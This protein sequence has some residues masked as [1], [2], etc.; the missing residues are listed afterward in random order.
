MTG[1]NIGPFLQNEEH[2]HLFL[3]QEELARV[4]ELIGQ[5]ESYQHK[6]F[7]QTKESAEAWLAK[8]LAIPSQGAEGALVYVC[9][10]DSSTL[11][12][13]PDKPHEHVCPKCGRVYSGGTYDRVWRAFTHARIAVAARDLALT[14][15]LTEDELYAR[16]AA[17]IL[18]AY[19]DRYASFPVVNLSKVGREMWDDWRSGLSMA[20]AY[21]LIYNSGVL[22][23]A[24]QLHIEKDLLL[25]TARLIQIAHGMMMADRVGGG[26]SNFQAGVAAG[27]GALALF[28]RDRE[29]ADFAINGP[30]GFNRLA[31]EGVL[32]SG[33]WWEGSFGYHGSVVHVFL[34]LAE[35]AWHSGLNLY[36]N[37]R[38]RSMFRAPLLAA[39]PDNT[40]P[41]TND[42]LGLSTK[43]ED[44]FRR[45][46]EVYYA[47]TG[48]ASVEPLLVPGHITGFDT[49]S[50][51]FDLALWLTPDWPESQPPP[52]Q[53]V[54]MAPNFAILR[55]N[56]DVE[57]I[58]LLLDYG[59][60]GGTHG[61]PDR[62]SIILYANGRLQA[63]DFGHGCDYRL[64]EWREWYQQTLSHNTVVVDGQSQHTGARLNLFYTSPRA[65]IADASPVT[66]R[67]SDDVPFQVTGRMRRTVALLDES[68]LVDIFRVQQG[69]VYDWVYH[70]FGSFETDD[71]RTEPEDR[72][73]EVN[74]YQHIKNVRRRKSPGD[75]W[76]G[77]W[78]SQ[79]QGLKLT[80]V[81]AGGM[82]IVTGD[83]LGPHID[84]ST[85]MVIA[86]SAKRDTVFKAVL[87]PFR[88]EPS[89]SRVKE[90]AV[91]RM[92]SFPPGSRQ[93]GTEGVGLKV[94]KQ[95][96][97]HHCFLLGY[98]WGVK[99]F[100]D[101]VFNGQMA[102]LS[103]EQR[104][105]DEGVL[106]SFVCATH[107]SRLERGQFRLRAD[108]MI[109]LHMQRVAPG[110]Y[111]LTNQDC[112]EVSIEIAGAAWGDAKVRR[113]DAEGNPSV[114]VDARVVD[115][116]LTFAAA[117][118]S[119]YC[120][121]FAQ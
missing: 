69:Q 44:R 65:K 107:T 33:L 23:H 2:P 121:A 76:S 114:E 4:R 98:A 9:S 88:G 94:E 21:D 41:A 38:F 101:I 48:D 52:P 42:G 86:R 27:V 74:G 53:S 26:I 56:P 92:S 30:V 47:R 55:T 112:A 113:F 50:D 109:S 61:H 43:V 12:Y 3:N 119:S 70:N 11:N 13:D 110:E 7:V 89:I 20:A 120:L 37:E 93:Q 102:F 60:H 14:Y 66:D 85:P 29:L 5:E 40:L 22:S 105:D 45:L 104:D 19:A 16:E 99:R 83:G 62:L 75:S 71:E 24:Q 28:L 25:E 35:A 81:G 91:E 59:P 36:T 73:G 54:N 117:A 32:D 77:T 111:V 46:A 15:A 39:L 82:E 97:A 80:L 64:P 17:S 51:P 96:G 8:P 103:Y 68:F 31:A 95:D 63:P 90:M 118:K 18:L 78:R 58:Y 67:W 106:P 108:R 87:E 100:D 84:E 1:L 6:R 115:G 57:E 72:L 34:F 116:T 49:E 10:A 79:G